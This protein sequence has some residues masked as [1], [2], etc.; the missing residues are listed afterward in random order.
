MGTG[1]VGPSEVTGRAKRGWRGLIQAASL[2]VDLLLFV[3]VFGCVRYAEYRDPVIASHPHGSQ[4][5]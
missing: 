5:G 1:F 2:G 3:V 4:P